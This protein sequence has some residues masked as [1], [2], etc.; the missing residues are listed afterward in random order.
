MEEKWGGESGHDKLLGN[1]KNDMIS[2][3][4]IYITNKK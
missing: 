4:S 1:K 3:L 2:Y